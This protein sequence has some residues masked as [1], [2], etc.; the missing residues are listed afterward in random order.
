MSMYKIGDFEFPQNLIKQYVPVRP[1]QRMDKGSYTDGYGVTQRKVLAHT[2]T[3]ISFTTLEMTGDEMR[4][5]MSN[6]VR[7]YLNS[8]ERDVNITYWDDEHGAFKTGHF[9]LDPSFEY[10]IKE[11]DDSGIPIRYGEMKWTFVEY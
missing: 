9:Y 7:N 4:N 8:L 5:I 3:Q 10:N 2:K 6:I 1:N 11:I